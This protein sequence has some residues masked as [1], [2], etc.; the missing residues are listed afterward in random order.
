MPD[1]QRRIAFVIAASDQGTFIL[2]R[3]DYNVAGDSTFGVGIEM[4]EGGTYGKGDIDVLFSLAKLRRKYFGDGVEV[5][6][7]G[8][9]MGIYT[10]NWA[11]RMAD[12]GNVLAI[13][14][15]ERVFYAL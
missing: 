2:N 9:N 5:I 8:A 13:E 11:Q 12:W 4:L 1:P 3:L 15:Q 10:V 7:C 6:D 14:A